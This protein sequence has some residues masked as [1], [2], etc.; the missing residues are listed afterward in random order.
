MT[1]RSAV[2]I[3]VT[4]SNGD[5]VF[6]ANGTLLLAEAQSYAQSQSYPV[7]VVSTSRNWTLAPGG[8]GATYLY[9]LKSFPNSFGTST[10]FFSPSSSTGTSFYLWG[11]QGFDP[12][13]VGVPANN[14]VVQSISATMEFSGMTIADLHLTPGTYNY[15]LPRDSI[16]LIIPSSVGG[17]NLRVPDSGLTG[18]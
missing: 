9:E 13:L 11:N 5:V 15:S 14:D 1:S 7:G 2:T 18:V 16:T 10:K 6:S 8:G 12:A 4:E 3:N 17:P